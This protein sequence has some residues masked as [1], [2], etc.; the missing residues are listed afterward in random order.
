ME[1]STI[2]SNTEADDWLLWQPSIYSHINRLLRRP[3][4]MNG[5]IALGGVIIGRVDRLNR[6]YDCLEKREKAM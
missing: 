2:V 3:D 4:N 6:I 5:Y 1:S